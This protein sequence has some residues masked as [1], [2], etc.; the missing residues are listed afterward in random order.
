MYNAHCFCAKREVFCF[1]LLPI[2]LL[3]IGYLS[4]EMLVFA[5]F[6]PAAW[7]SIPCG[8]TLWSWV[9]THTHTI[10]ER[11][12]KKKLYK[13][14]GGPPRTFAPR[15]MH[16]FWCRW[17]N[18]R[19]KQTVLHTKHSIIESN[20]WYKYKEPRTLNREKFKW[21][22]KEKCTR[23]TRKSH[24]LAYERARDF[25][26]CAL[27]WALMVEEVEAL[28]SRMNSRERPSFGSDTLI[29]RLFRAKMRVKAH[30]AAHF[31]RHP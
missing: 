6:F 7:I 23:H 14:S 4:Q 12:W 31:T 24:R 22:K 25:A 29:C 9:K 1:I 16:V 17:P 8:G 18:R 30:D 21:S 20:V 27:M 5:R 15:C 26:T 2:A 10:N 28:R 13:R 19:R 3:L 11:K